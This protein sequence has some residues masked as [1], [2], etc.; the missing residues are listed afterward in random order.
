MRKQATTLHHR[1]LRRRRRRRR[2]R[3]LVRLLS[4]YGPPCSALLSLLPN[5]PCSS[6]TP[7]HI[8]LNRARRSF[9]SWLTE[10]CRPTGAVVYWLLSM[11]QSHPNL[12]WRQ[13]GKLGRSQQTSP[14]LL[15]DS[16]NFK[17][18][19]L[20]I[21]MFRT[22]GQGIDYHNPSSWSLA[23]TSHLPPPS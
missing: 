14:T 15:C 7:S 2:R 3:R 18:A 10:P 22:S 12:L 13:L 16:F 17:G 9:W 20:C 1:V 21:I 6:V 5:P 8:L 4:C 19:V 23:W 11:R